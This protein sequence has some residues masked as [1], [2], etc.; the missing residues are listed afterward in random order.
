MPAGVPLEEVTLA[1]SLRQQG[2]ATHIVGKWDAGFFQ[3]EY[4]PT[5]RGFDSFF[6]KQ[7]F[8]DSIGIGSMLSYHK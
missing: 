3:H 8:H 1:E 5:H 4:L 7:Y 6:G 2:Y